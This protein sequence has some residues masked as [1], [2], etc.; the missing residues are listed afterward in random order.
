MRLT[1]GDEDDRPKIEEKH[2][3]SDAKELEAI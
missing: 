1:G 3:E 2:C